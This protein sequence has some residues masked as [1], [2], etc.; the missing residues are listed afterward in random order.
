MSQAALHN[1]FRF[2][3]QV[4]ATLIV[5]VGVVWWASRPPVP[6]ED[7]QLIEVSRQGDEVFVHGTYTKTREDCRYMSGTAYAALPG[8]R[9]AVPFTPIRGP[10]QDAQREPG[11]QHMRVIVDLTGCPWCD[12]TDIQFWARHDC[13]GQFVDTLMWELGVPE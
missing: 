2:L 3:S 5:A 8:D 6:Y 9:Q 13:S 7:W 1:I 11:I 12:A 4:V 10:G